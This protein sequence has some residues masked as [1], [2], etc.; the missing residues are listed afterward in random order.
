MKYDTPKQHLRRLYFERF[1]TWLKYLIFSI[2]G[3][4]AI[5]VIYI[6]LIGGNDTQKLNECLQDHSLNYCNNN[7]R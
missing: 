1:I 7:V 3:A 4:V 2:M 6:C 5:G